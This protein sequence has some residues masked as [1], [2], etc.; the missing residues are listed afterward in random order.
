MIILILRNYVVFA[1]SCTRNYLI[2][3]SNYY[4]FTVCYLVTFIGFANIVLN[5]LKYDAA[6]MFITYTVKKMV[7]KN[8]QKR[9]E[10]GNIIAKEF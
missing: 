7:K 10:Y 5:Q 9:F 1:F 2:L 4:L 8:I 6:K 3:R